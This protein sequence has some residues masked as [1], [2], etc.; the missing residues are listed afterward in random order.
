MCAPAVIPILG[1]IG[2]GVT[3]LQ[4]L[5]VFGNRGNQTQQSFKPTA[6]PTVKD[7]PPTMGAGEDEKTKKVDESIKI[8]Q[9]PAQKRDKRKANLG[10]ENLGAA[11]AVNTGI[12]PTTNPSGTPN[13]GT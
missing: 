13:I 10:L 3:A 12:A 1:A 9:N 4:S 8:Q 5:G 11:A 7:A 6:A 2:G